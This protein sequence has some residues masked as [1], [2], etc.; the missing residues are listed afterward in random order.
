MILGGIA[1]AQVPTETFEVVVNPAFFQINQ[2]V[3]VTITAKKNGAVNTA[4]TGMVWLSI[5]N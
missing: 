3:D 4:Y 2:S 1:V 5:R